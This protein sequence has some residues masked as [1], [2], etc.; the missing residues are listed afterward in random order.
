MFHYLLYSLKF[1]IDVFAKTFISYI[2]RLEIENKSP[3]NMKKMDPGMITV[4]T[5]KL[6]EFKFTKKQSQ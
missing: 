6:E 1:C 4:S 5:L 2:Y 3:K